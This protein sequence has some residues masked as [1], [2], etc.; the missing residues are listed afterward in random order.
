M[1]NSAVLCCVCVCVCS[2]AECPG[3][4]KTRWAKWLQ[5]RPPAAGGQRKEEGSKVPMMMLDGD[6]MG[7]ASACTS[8]TVSAR[9]NTSGDTAS[10]CG[11]LV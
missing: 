9:S 1:P 7:K 8:P 3:A 5:E 11:T 4:D 10:R 6:G 2:A